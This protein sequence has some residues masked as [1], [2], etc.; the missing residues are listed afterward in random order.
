LKSLFGEILFGDSNLVG[1]TP[2]LV[3]INLS[4][5]QRVSAFHAAAQT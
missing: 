5:Y 2:D 3:A 1:R 4:N